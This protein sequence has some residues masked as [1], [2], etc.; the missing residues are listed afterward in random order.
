MLQI[1]T[2]SIWNYNLQ[3][4]VCHV[5]LDYSVFQFTM[6]FSITFSPE[7]LSHSEAVIL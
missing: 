4:L 6:E 2:K 7:P 1:P 3:T 5:I